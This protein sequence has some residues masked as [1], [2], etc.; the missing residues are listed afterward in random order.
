MERAS[1]ICIGENVLT[2]TPVAWALRTVIGNWGFKKFLKSVKVAEM[3]LMLENNPNYYLDVLP[4][5]MIMGLSK[6]LDKKTEFLS[7][8]D[9]A[10]GFD[11]ATFASS[12]FGSIRSGLVTRGKKERK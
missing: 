10:D 9:W 7:A 6:K 12:M 11:G 2:T 8:P 5:C 4:Y 1:V 3:E